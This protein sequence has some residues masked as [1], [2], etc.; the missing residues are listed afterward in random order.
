[1]F[2]EENTYYEKID[3]VIPLHRYHYMLRAVLETIHTFY[4]PK[5]IYI[6]TPKCYCEII[7]INKEYWNVNSVTVIPEETF[8]KNTYNLDYKNINNYFTKNINEKNREFGWWYQQ[9]IK[10]GA[11]KEIQNLSDPYIVWDSD[12]IPL[13]K[14]EIY[15]TIEENYYKIAILQ[16]NAK[17]EWISEQ[18]KESLLYLTDL[19]IIDPLVGTFVPHHYVFFHNVLNDLLNIIET[20]MQLCWIKSIILLSKT[21]YRFSEYRAVSS[22]MH[23]KYP[24]LLNYHSY[25]KFGKSGKRIRENKDFLLEIEKFLKD[26]KI[27][28]SYGI[29]K[30]DFIKF[31]KQ[32][33]NILPSYL[34]IE[35]I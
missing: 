30:E 18:Y 29:S 27:N 4:S 25:E 22:L 14:W 34:Q 7:N 9:L 31:A 3:F 11:F 28:I 20:K 32:K 2:T 33:Y 12:L 21:F 16:E 26:E 19:P 6:I 24:N 23:I 35:H 17:S 1:M 13:I 10:L 15:P 5:N 8:F